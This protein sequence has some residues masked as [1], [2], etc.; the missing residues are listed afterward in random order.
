VPGRQ[1]KSGRRPKP[2]A[3]HKLEGTFNVTRHGKRRANEPKPQGD[4]N[5]PP[6]DLTP[7]QAEVWRHVMAN[8]PAGLLKQLDR[9]LL[10]GWVEAE[11]RHNTARLMQA[12]IDSSTEFK[13]MIRSHNGDM[14][15]SPYNDILDKTLRSMTRVAQELG[16]SPVA[17]P[18]IQ[19]DPPLQPIEAPKEDAWSTLRRFP[20]ISGGKTTSGV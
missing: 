12:K 17:R 14:V 1:G 10:K 8:A 6:K 16:F 15:P 3:L 13:L 2:T 18:R 4:L 20:V 19:V 11:D 9:G 5:A 7:G